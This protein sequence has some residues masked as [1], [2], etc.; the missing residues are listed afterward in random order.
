VP[1]NPSP[2]NTEPAPEGV[3]ET[4]T[5]PKQ[6]RPRRAS[7]KIRKVVSRKVESVVNDVESR[8][9]KSSTHPLRTTVRW[10]VM[11]PGLLLLYAA[12]VFI[13]VIVMGPGAWLLGLSV[14]LGLFALVTLLVALWARRRRH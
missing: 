2:P 6:R 7:R 3:P 1:T 9:R 4:A 10:A 13:V 12:E 11:V 14:G 5:I 8:M